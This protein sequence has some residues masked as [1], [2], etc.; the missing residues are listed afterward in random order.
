MPLETF[1]LW[2]PREPLV[3]VGRSS[4]MALEVSLDRCRALGIPILRRISG[5]AA[6]VTGPGCLMYALILSYQLRPKL[7]ALSQAH[8]WVLDTLVAALGAL[9]PGVQCQGTSDLAIGDLKFSGNSVRCR[10]NHLLYHGT[11]LYDFPL[12]L[13]EKCLDMPPKTPDYRAGRSHE[14]FVTNLPLKPEAIRTA[15][16]AA[17][18]AHEP[19]ATWPE[20]LTAKLAAEKYRRREWNEGHA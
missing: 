2:E 3:V 11:L 9:T 15:L 13:I 7:R 8:H 19:C 16:I 12:P 6:I 1:R 18:N 17:F 4:K 14:G 20:E 5:G 10:R